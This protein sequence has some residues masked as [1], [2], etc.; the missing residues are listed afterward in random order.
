MGR[1]MV[2][3][4]PN[5]PA[6]SRNASLAGRRHTRLALM[7]LTGSAALLGG[8]SAEGQKRPLEML[9]QLVPG[10]WQ[11]REHGTGTSNVNLCLSSGRQLIQFRHPGQVCKSVVVQDSSDEVV[12]QYVC[13]GQ[14]YGRTHIRRETNGLI[15]LD[16]QGIVGGQ[17]F[18]YAGE[19][20]RTGL[21]R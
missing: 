14:G 20:R 6:F 4:F 10:S 21:C 5:F 16:T 12:V 3:R 19:G 11:L 8:A 17:P 1:M 15:Q 13:S 9:D 7:A 2:P 18:D